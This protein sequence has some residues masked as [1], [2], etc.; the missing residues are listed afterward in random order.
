MLV[1][2]YLSPRVECKLHNAQYFFMFYV[3]IYPK[4]CL[5]YSRHALCI[6]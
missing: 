2:Y 6:C 1:Y 3:L 4:Q 5:E